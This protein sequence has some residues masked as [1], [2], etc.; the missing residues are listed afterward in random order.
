MGLPFVI[1]DGDAE[2]C[3]NLTG[4]RLKEGDLSL[5]G[6]PRDVIE[7]YYTGRSLEAIRECK[8]I[9]LGDGAAG[10][11][12]LIDR[13]VNDNFDKDS[14]VTHG[15]RVTHWQTEIQEKPFKLRI[16]DFGGQEILHS[17]HRC[18]LTAHTVY[19]V[20]C[21]S[22]DDAEIDDTAARW[23]ATV[24]A[25][26]PGC[27]VILALNKADM[28][29]NVS[30][31]ERDL[32]TRY[33]ALKHVLRTSAKVERDAKFGTN[34]LTEVIREEIPGCINQ[35]QANADM[36]AVKRALEEMTEDYITADAY[37][38]L[39][40]KN[41]LTDQKLQHQMLGFFKD[42]GVA[43][44]YEKEDGELDARLESVRVLNPAWLTNGIYRL[45]V[46]APESGFLPHDEIRK[47]LGR[48]FE[49]D[50][51]KTVYSREETEFILHV[52]RQF[53]ISHIMER[54]GRAVEVIPMKMPK[55]T[56]DLA[57]RFPKD[58]AL[59]LRW[60]GPYLPNNLVHRLMI[61]KFEELDTDCVWRTGGQFKKQDSRCVALASMSGN[62]LDVYVTGKGNEK[63]YM[64]GFR[65]EIRR[66]LGVLNL[67]AE[68]WICHWYLGREGKIPYDVVMDAWD[69]GDPF[70]LFQDT[71]ERIPPEELLK[72]TYHSVQKE[73]EAYRRDRL[74]EEARA[75]G[76]L[77]PL[78]ESTRRMNNAVTVKTREETKTIRAQR[79]VYIGLVVLLGILAVAGHW[80][81]V[82]EIIKKL[83]S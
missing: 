25:F 63:E 64:E 74:P 59:H 51:D 8:V 62:A 71:K 66:I 57:L 4:V 17:M 33:P 27:P 49:G 58:K 39:C 7:A 50:I 2:N 23:L 83:I 60:E 73:K 77:S 78:E 16:L 52:M 21:E 1:D 36:L 80:E 32:R 41:H 47:T 53:E 75:G 45:I 11:S 40:D 22:R 5:F 72:A 3:I 34:A 35:Y 26:A 69:N 12:C 19:V 56:P 13:I 46:R 37:R 67:K 14:P 79:F 20:V 55:D 18:F 61:R 28:N 44:Y 6:Q 9:F 24:Q 31:N 29:A 15:V 65:D 43:Y 81:T 76:K 82:L 48:A 68:E 30:V 54:D 70:V 42:L 10:K 38:E